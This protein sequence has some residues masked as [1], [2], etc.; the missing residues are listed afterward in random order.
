MG[1]AAQG[2]QPAARSSAVNPGKE[3]A[4]S[5]AARHWADSVFRTLSPEQRI[6]Q[7]I[8]VRAYS[9]QGAAHVREVTRLVRD[10][11][12][13]GLVFFQ[14]GPVRQ[15]S[16]TNYYQRL[17]K[18]PL[19]VS[20]D[21]EWGLGMRLDSVISFP[22]QLQLGAVQDS[23]LIYRMGVAVGE[24][25]RRMGIQINFAPVVDINNNP[26][27]PVIN[28][29]SFGENKYRVARWG[30]QYMQGMQRMGILA[31]AKHFPG[32][33]DTNTDSHKALPTINKSMAQLHALEL[34]PFQQMVRA[35]VAAVMV[36][37]LDIPAI[38]KRP[39][40][41]T[42]LSYK[43]VTGLLKGE[44]G[45]TGIVFT[46]ALGMQGVAGY[47]THGQ[48]SVEALR[49]GNDALLLPQD[50]DESITAVR[51]AIG[52]GILRQSEIDARV[53]KIL[54]AKYAAGLSQWEP[55]ETAHLVEDLNSHT[56]ALKDSLCRASFT[57]LR[58]E[59]N[60][61][62]LRAEKKEK[63]ACLIIGTAGNH[64][65]V[66]ELK[67]YRSVDAYYF[68]GGTYAAGAALADRLK[69]GYDRVIVA[70]TGY[71]RYPA[72]NYGISQPE[73]QLVKQLTQE[74]PS[75]AVAF[76]NPYAIR[77]FCEAPAL[78]AAYEDD[79]TMSRIAASVIFG[80]TDPRGRLPVTVCPGLPSGKGL[81]DFASYRGYLP[82]VPPEKLGMNPALLKEVDSIARDGI[83]RG[84]YPGC[85]ILGV[86]DG[87]IFYQKAFGTFSYTDKR[88]M[89]TETVFDLASVTKICATTLSCMRLYDEGALRLDKT[90]GDYL[91]WLRGTDKARLTIKNVMLHQAG[92]I[93]DFPYRELLLTD[94]RQPNTDIFHT[95]R[96]SA[97]SV[98][99][100]ENM[101]MRKD[102]EDTLKAEIRD[103][104]LNHR[105]G[106]VYSDI[107][108]QLMGYIVEE[109]T[110]LRLDE[111][112]RKTF[113]GPIGM[114]STG[115]LPRERYPPDEI[116]PTECEKEFR[117]QCLRGD[118]HDPRAAMFGGVAGHAG[119]FSTA[120]D[121]GMLMQMLLNGGS[122][123]G[124]Q[125]IK[126]GTIKL[127]TDY[128]TSLSRR[129]I[130]FDKPE[131]DRSGDPS[132][133]PSAKCSDQTFGHTGYTGT[134]VWVDP[135][136]RFT[137][138]FL[139]NRVNPDGGANL[140]LSHMDIRGKIQDAFYT[141]MGR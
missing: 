48:A 5:S 79:A 88:P 51:A 58:N 75:V 106:Y 95:V 8:F 3:P 49:A 76:G 46:D 135:Q 19:F 29:R 101:Y 45:F 40:R 54:M 69:K 121:L 22:R 11:H 24:Q 107:D 31:C 139:S 133:Y 83:A 53:K 105:P 140:K 1:S 36:A 60:M 96:D 111:Y 30:I 114:I 15:A 70:V 138:V 71:S 116:A 25:C 118:V 38:D 26:E 109:I 23:S 78:L 102:Y 136:Y 64:P 59:N 128:S 141:A 80:K 131:K 63:L 2:Q 86:R 68:S 67:K 72:H 92:F 6:A 55:V 119:L 81:T 115:F 61:L 77:N 129:G 44:L 82:Y 65:L 110:G 97:Y 73:V 4:A 103:S 124:R 20:I 113:Y 21:G 27:N 108:F 57:A 91:P 104:K 117:M 47:F 39:H 35:G 13:G 52:K 37:H 93:P 66:Q 16:L 12:V 132:P 17:A 10:K 28:D 84:A 7:L 56:A 42:S 87:R 85:V 100:A 127:F 122:W 120:Y 34:Y 89:T 41:P 90:L 94:D 14:G 50:V 130:G 74:M 98:R 9:N 62:P 18:V 112:V 125:Y 43:N 137:Y 126:P 123:N 134:C 99:V 33:G 32:H